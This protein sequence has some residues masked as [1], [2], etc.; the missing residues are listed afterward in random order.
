MSFT[1]PIRNDSGRIIG[2]GRTGST[3]LVTSICNA[4]LAAPIPPPTPLA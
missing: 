4:V 3:G 1:Y 2:S